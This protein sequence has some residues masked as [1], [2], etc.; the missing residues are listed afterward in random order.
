MNSEMEMTEKVGGVTNRAKCAEAYCR[1]KVVRRADLYCE[2]HAHLEPPADAETR[3]AERKWPYDIKCLMCA[4]Q[5]HAVWT[6][7]QRNLW[8]AS[9][10]LRCGACRGV[11]EIEDGWAEPPSEDAKRFLQAAPGRTEAY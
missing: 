8:V 6:T 5:A 11:V 4:R 7:A 10:M 1:A 2:L 3:L 9:G